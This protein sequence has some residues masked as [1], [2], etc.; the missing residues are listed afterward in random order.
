MCL[1]FS[2]SLS[3]SPFHLSIT[4]TSLW[5]SRRSRAGKRTKPLH[6]H[7]YHYHHNHYQY[8]YSMALQRWRSTHQGSSRVWQSIYIQRRIN[9][10]VTE[11]T[12]LYCSML[13]FRLF[14]VDTLISVATLLLLLL[15]LLLLCI[16]VTSVRVGC[17][18][19]SRSI[20]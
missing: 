17:V 5:Q 16:V 2:P 15:L 14:R 10:C 18:S 13:L 4:S 1:C 9:P 3:L 7:Y 8:Q 19:I 20:W 11:F 12:A 6:R